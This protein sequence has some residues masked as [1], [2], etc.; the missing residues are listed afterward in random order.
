MKIVDLILSNPDQANSAVA[1]SMQA[2]VFDYLDNYQL[3]EESIDE[4]TNTVTKD[5]NGKITGWKHEGDWEKSKPTT[6]KQAMSKVK[7]DTEGARK[8]SERLTKEDLDAM[9]QEEFE[10]LVEDFEQLDE[11]SKATLGS[12]IKKSAVDAKFK[13]FDAG[14]TEGSESARS[15]KMGGGSGSGMK[16]DEKAHSRLKGIKTAVN[17]LTK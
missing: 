7:A 17:K 14:Y 3:A 10:A 16:D 9:D 4:A 6:D 13:G 5:K 8:W 15:K 2:R 1:D 11:L 12:Y